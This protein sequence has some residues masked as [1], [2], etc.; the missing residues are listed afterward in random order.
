MTADV[1]IRR[2]EPVEAHLAAFVMIAAR[3]ANEPAIPPM[4]HTDAEV[5]SWFANVVMVEQEVW[6]GGIVPTSDISTHPIEAVLA[7]TPGWIEHLYVDPRCANYGL[8]SALVE[9]AKRGAASN[10][11]LWT[12]AANLGARRFYERHGFI[13]VD[14]TDGENEEGAPDIRYRWQ[15]ERHESD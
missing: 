5:L 7:L 6:I 15:Y 2:A 1:W 3:H 11:D 12:F 9:H 10:I 4:V 13:E 14:R 8:G